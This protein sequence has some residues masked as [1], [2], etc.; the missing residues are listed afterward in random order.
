M[1]THIENTAY[2]SIGNTEYNF[3]SL[4]LVRRFSDKIVALC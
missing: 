1:K 4:F 3:C 2:V